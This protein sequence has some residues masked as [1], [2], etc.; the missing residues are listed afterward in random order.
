MKVITQLSAIHG[1]GV[2]AREPIRC[3]EVVLRIDDSR[4]VD[5]AHPVREDLGEDPDHCDWLPD[6]TIVLMQAPERYINHSCDPNV[7]AY[8]VDYERFI[9]ARRDIAAGEEL[10]WDY[11]INAFAGGTWTCRCGAPNCRGHHQCGFF[12]L[13][14]RRQ[15]E[16]L[17]I[18]DPWF[19]R[20]H[21]DR[22]RDL[23]KK[24]T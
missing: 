9:I 2:F 18:T 20:V 11:A 5:D 3:G 1:T 13:P 16:Y 6:G 8:S 15:L 17:P 22:I 24:H 4:I 7:Y 19:A 10:L 23:L 14:E 21:A 12:S